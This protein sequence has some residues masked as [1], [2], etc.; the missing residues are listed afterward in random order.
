[1]RSTTSY[2]VA[3]VIT[4]TGLTPDYDSDGWLCYNDYT[5]EMVAECPSYLDT[6]FSI[7]TKISGYM[8]IVIS[9]C[10]ASSDCAGF[11]VYPNTE[12]IVTWNHN[13]IDARKATAQTSVITCFDADF[14]ESDVSKSCTNSQGNPWT[15][16]PTLSPTTFIPTASPVQSS[17]GSG[18]SQT[19]IISIIV[20]SVLVGLI[21]IYFGLRL[22]CNWR[23]RKNFIKDPSKYNIFI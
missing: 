8:D 20:C 13:W 1:M 19:A 17:A 5:F 23:L 12:S 7:D 11:T 4:V 14:A 16:S 22:C 10:G 21:I 2:L 6:A 18:L 15:A 3:F 9:M